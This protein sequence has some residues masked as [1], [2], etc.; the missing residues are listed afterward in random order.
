MKESELLSRYVITACCP[1]MNRRFTHK[2]LSEP[3][4]ESLISVNMDGIVFHES[5]PKLSQSDKT[6]SL[7]FLLLVVSEAAIVTDIS[8]ILKQVCLIQGATVHSGKPAPHL[9]EQHEY[10]QGHLEGVSFVVH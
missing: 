4:Y 10:I 1:K 6:F 5:E 8:N 3:Y 9:D 7:E 2:F